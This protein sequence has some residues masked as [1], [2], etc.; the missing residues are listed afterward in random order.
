MMLDEREAHRNLNGSPIEIF[1][2]NLPEMA[3]VG[4]VS[5]LFARLAGA[6]SVRLKQGRR[7]TANGGY[8]FVL[9][10]SVAEAAAAVSALQGAV[11]MGKP[12]RCVNR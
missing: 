5:Q 9:F 6:R 4:D 1:V 3:T 8:G 12:L 7:G 11:F 2:G 10:S